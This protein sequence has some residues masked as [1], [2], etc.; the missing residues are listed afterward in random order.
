[1]TCDAVEGDVLEGDVANVLV[2][3]MSGEVAA[4]GFVAN[5][6]T[7]DLPVWLHA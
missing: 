5:A 1:M 4:S 2:A 7:D 6:F 3:T